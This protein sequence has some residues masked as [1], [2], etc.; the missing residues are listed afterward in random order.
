M[1]KI[2]FVYVKILRYPWI[3]KFLVAPWNWYQKTDPF[4]FSLLLL[5]SN[6]SSSQT[7]R[8][9]RLANEASQERSKA[10]KNYFWLGRLEK[11]SNNNHNSSSHEWLKF[12]GWC[13]RWPQADLRGQYQV[14]K[15]SV[16]IYRV[17]AGR[18]TFWVDNRC[19]HEWKQVLWVLC[20]FLFDTIIILPS[21]A[22]HL[23]ESYHTYKPTCWASSFPN[24]FSHETYLEMPSWIGSPL[25]KTDKITVVWVEAEGG[26]EVEFCLFCH[27]DSKCLRQNKA[28]LENLC[29]KILLP[30]MESPYQWGKWMVKLL[31]KQKQKQSPGVLL[32][33]N[34]SC[35]LSFCSPLRHLWDVDTHWS[36][37]QSTMLSLARN[38]LLPISSSPSLSLWVLSQHLLHHTLHTF[39][40]K[41]PKQTQPKGFAVFLEPEGYRGQR[42]VRQVV[43]LGSSMS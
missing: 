10:R 5:R 14:V 43:H 40:F 29:P 31:K 2:H 4:Q 27:P 42:K 21:Q 1:Y 38:H 22:C 8:R 30:S 36:C 15:N 34:S 28:R 23:Q 41:N 18:V 13:L 9:P 24:I 12:P 20:Y 37:L 7:L 17:V 32:I 26:K 19:V 6:F 11:H 3:P 25:Y 35:C 39:L 33:Y 16:N